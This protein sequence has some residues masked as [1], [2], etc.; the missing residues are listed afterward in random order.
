MTDV[1]LSA[2]ATLI[3]AHWLTVSHRQRPSTN[4]GIVTSCVGLFGPTIKCC[5]R[6]G[7]TVKRSA[8]TSLWVS[9]PARPVEDKN[10]Q[11]HDGYEHAGG[12]HDYSRYNFR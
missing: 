1:P 11:R 2:R 3:H 5:V 6:V 7:S 8:G 10:Q 9:V 4:L 12:R